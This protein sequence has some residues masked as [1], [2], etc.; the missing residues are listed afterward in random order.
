MPGKEGLQKKLTRVRKPRV[1][2]VMDVATGNAIEMPELPF[3]V[4]VVGDFSG[5]PAEP[6]ASLRDRR[7]VEVNPDNFDD[8]LKT[9]KP[10]LSLRVD[11]RLEK[12]KADAGQ[13][14][15]VLNFE[16]LEDF[17][18]HKVAEQVPY[19]KEML[20]LRTRLN[21]LKGSM[22]GRTSFEEMLDEAIRDKDK[23]AELA[24]QIKKFKEG[25][26]K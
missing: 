18:P 6:L 21:D 10:R 17:E 9:M 11:N 20:D 12:D 1:H 19:L 26:Q 8:V 3:I 23:R 5:Q 16:T 14:S 4:G 15:A 24:E 2:I 22:D 7:F 13:L 25:Q